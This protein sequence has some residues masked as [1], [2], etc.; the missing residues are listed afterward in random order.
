MCL[1]CKHFSHA[2]EARLT[3]ELKN[4]VVHNSQWHA[5]PGAHVGLY[6]LDQVKGVQPDAFQDTWEGA[7]HHPATHASGRQAYRCVWECSGA[8]CRLLNVDLQSPSV[9]LSMATPS[10]QTRRSNRIRAY[11]NRLFIS[12]HTSK[13]LRAKTSHAS[14]PAVNDSTQQQQHTATRCTRTHL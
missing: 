13:V 11:R 7:R 9:C 6:N 5:R 12:K 14:V 8:Q 3:G 1:H 4:K 2:T 10:S